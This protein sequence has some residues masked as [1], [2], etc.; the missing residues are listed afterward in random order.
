MENI[1]ELDG[2][3]DLIVQNETNGESIAVITKGEN[4]LNRLKVALQEEYSDE[5]KSIVDVVS[6]NVQGKWYFT[7]ILEEY[8]TQNIELNRAFIY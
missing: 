5:I 8:G 6:G 2:K 7:I 4:Q 3:L 1:L